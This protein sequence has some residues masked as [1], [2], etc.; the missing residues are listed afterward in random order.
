[1]NHIP[2]YQLEQLFDDHFDQWFSEVRF[3]ALT[4]TPSDVLKSTDPIAY[5]QEFLFWLDAQIDNGD[6]IEQDG[7][8]FLPEA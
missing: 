5:R 7:E 1:M 8:Y 2:E 6:L 3:G 4:Y